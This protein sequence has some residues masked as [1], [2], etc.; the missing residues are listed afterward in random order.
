M[1]RVTHKLPGICSTYIRGPA[2][3]ERENKPAINQ[4]PPEVLSCIMLIGVESDGRVWRWESPGVG[5]QQVAAQ[6]CRYW[7]HV[8]ISTPGLWTFIHIKTVLLKHPI[9]LYLFRAGPSALLDIVIDMPSQSHLHDQDGES[10]RHILCS[11]AT[12]GASSDRWRTLFIRPH[13]DHSKIYSGLANFFH[14][15]SASSLQRLRLDSSKGTDTS[16]RIHG[17]IGNTGTRDSEDFRASGPSLTNLRCLEVILRSY[18]PTVPPTLAREFTKLTT[19]SITYK[20]DQTELSNILL[21]NPYLESLQ[22]DEDK[23]YSFSD[24]SLQQSSINLV[25]HATAPALRSLFIHTKGGASWVL[26]MVTAIKAPALHQFSFGCAD[27]HPEDL[28][29]LV[30]YI[31]TGILPSH[32][33]DSDSGRGPIYSSLQNLDVSGFACQKKDFETLISS[34]PHLTHLSVCWKTV[35]RWDM[36]E[37]PRLLSNLQRLGFPDFPVTDTILMSFLSRGIEIAAPIKE[38]G[39]RGGRLRLRTTPHKPPDFEIGRPWVNLGYEYYQYEDGI[40]RGDLQ[41]LQWTY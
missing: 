34:F 7:H 18:G 22:L 6:V 8:A 31:T 32:L 5:S 13:K 40:I 30:T 24:I 27:H 23:D 4:L 11:L 39:V 21:S 1:L 38:I 29:C 19:L 2:P 20:L 33:T 15:N 10:F 36:N 37:A 3:P 9:S 17:P 12:L 25:R 16:F 14:Q 35:R 41:S 26:R 28:H